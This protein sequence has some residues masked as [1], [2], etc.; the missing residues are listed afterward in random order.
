MAVPYHEVYAAPMRAAAAKLREAAALADDAGLRRY[1]ELR[2]R[3]LETDEYQPSD[4]A[5]LDMKTNADRRGHRPD[6]DL[7]RPAVRL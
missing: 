7:H 6:R 1:L 4:L 3:A 2:A 5:W